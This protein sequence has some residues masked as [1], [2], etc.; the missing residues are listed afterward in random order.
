MGTKGKEKLI[1]SSVEGKQLGSFA[2]ANTA[3]TEYTKAEH[4]KASEGPTDMAYSYQLLP[5]IQH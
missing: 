3:H 1:I 2:S 4:K 5:P